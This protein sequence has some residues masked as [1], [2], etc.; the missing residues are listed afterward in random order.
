MQLQEGSSADYLPAALPKDSGPDWCC[1]SPVSASERGVHHSLFLQGLYDG[2]DVGRNL[3][4]KPQ[5][6]KLYPLEIQKFAMEKSP[7]E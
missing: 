4:V 5:V 2:Y 1:S 3:R 6:L 7:F